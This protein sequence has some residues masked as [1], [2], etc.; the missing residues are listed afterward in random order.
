MRDEPQGRGGDQWLD[1]A[2]TTGDATKF[3]TGGGGGGGIDVNPDG[4][5]LFSTQATGEANDFRMS[6]LNGVMKLQPEASQIGES[7]YEAAYFS[8][9]HEAGAE[10]LRMFTEDA[11]KGLMALGQGAQTIAIDY[12]NGDATT[13]AT[14]QDVQSAFDVS[15]GTGMFNRPVPAETQA[16]TSAGG[17]TTE[18]VLPPPQPAGE[19]DNTPYDPNAAR[20]VS[21]GQGSYTIPA[22]APDDLERIDLSEVGEFRQK[23]EDDLDKTD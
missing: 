15:G 4:V 8:L 17:G 7:F 1:R 12:I 11:G 21:L 3:L 14:M 13:A 10:A 20:T 6:N 9:E 2:P 22:D 16:P 18:G 5:K 23:F 19:Q